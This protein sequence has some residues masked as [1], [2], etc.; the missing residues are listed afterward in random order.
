MTNTN[1]LT[2]APENTSCENISPE[3]LE[4]LSGTVAKY[5]PVLNVMSDQ[6]RQT[7]SQIETAV[8]GVCTNFQEMATR[9]QSSVAK[10]SQFIAG[11]SGGRAGA[12]SLDKLASRARSTMNMLLRR[13]GEARAASRRALDQIQAINKATHSITE[14][15]ARLDDISQGNKLM[16]VNARIQAV[17]AGK[18]SGGFTAVAT[19]IASQARE[20]TAIVDSIRTMAEQL[21]RVAVAASAELQAMAETDERSFETSQRDVDEALD[22]FQRMHAT[23]EAMVSSMTEE[24]RAVSGQ[25]G[26]AVRALQF[27]DR[28]SQRIGHVIEEL[29]LL[30]DELE[31][32]CPSSEADGNALKHFSSRFTMHEEWHLVNG[33]EPAPQVSEVELF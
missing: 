25:I 2:V 26:E 10:A 19:E 22:E 15:L 18:V 30:H 21:N 5:L 1:S 6:L 9:T 12:V 32:N 33:A 7:V 16:A 17:N 14:A 27:Q 3:N 13:S 11:G 31:Q 20:S 29:R 8:I 28:V 23:L 4:A 24:S